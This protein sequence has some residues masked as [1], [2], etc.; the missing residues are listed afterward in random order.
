MLRTPLKNDEIG[1]DPCCWVLDEVEHS[2]VSRSVSALWVRRRLLSSSL[3]E[4][5]GLGGAGFVLLTNPLLSGI[6]CSGCSGLSLSD[7]QYELL[8]SVHPSSRDDVNLWKT[9]NKLLV[10]SEF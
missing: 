5:L 3:L 7:I 10:R 6:C 9:V 4:V 2:E 8:L 1:D